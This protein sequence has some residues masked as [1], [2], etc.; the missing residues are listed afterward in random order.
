K[1]IH[2]VLVTWAV[3]N[4]ASRAV[5]LKNGG[6]LEAVRAGKERYWIDLE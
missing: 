4:P 2:Q 3:D 5:I 1:N 6:I